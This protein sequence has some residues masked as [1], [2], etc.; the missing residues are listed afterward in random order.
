MSQDIIDRTDTDYIMRR[1]GDIYSGGLNR[2][3]GPARQMHMGTSLRR[4]GD[5]RLPKER[6]VGSTERAAGD[7][8]AISWLATDHS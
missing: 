3:N 1:I 7:C 5:S 8:F 6:T 4:L 2:H